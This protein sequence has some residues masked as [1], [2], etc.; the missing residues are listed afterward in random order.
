MLERLTEGVSAI[1]KFI[2]GFVVFVYLAIGAICFIAPPLI[3]F[4]SCKQNTLSVTALLPTTWSFWPVG[5]YN[6]FDFARRFDLPVGLAWI[7]RWCPVHVE[8]L[9]LS[10]ANTK[11]KPGTSK[12]PSVTIP[13]L[14]ISIQPRGGGTAW[15]S[16]SHVWGTII[17]PS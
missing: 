12:S 17:L 10:K 7:E 1:V 16:C 9:R 15:E 4:G 3:G 11:P 5:V 8:A 14:R 6:T 2:A 13:N